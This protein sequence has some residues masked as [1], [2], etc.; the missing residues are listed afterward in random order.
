MQLLQVSEQELLWA[1]RVSEVLAE[2]VRRAL[3][4]VSKVQLK[5]VRWELQD[6]LGRPEAMQMLRSVQQ[7]QDGWVQLQLPD[8]LQ[9][10][11]TQLQRLLRV[12]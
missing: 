2:G 4:K 9:V 7:V 10:R 1:V 6:V 12:S 11:A 5:N 8:L 3:Q